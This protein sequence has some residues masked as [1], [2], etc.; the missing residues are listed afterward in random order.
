MNK[1]GYALRK[2]MSIPERILHAVMTGLT[3]GLWYP[4]ARARKTHIER[5][6]EFYA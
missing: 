4:I 3:L 5:K 6:T 2:T 1:A